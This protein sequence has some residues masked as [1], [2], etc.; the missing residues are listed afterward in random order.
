MSCSQTSKTLRPGMAYTFSCLMIQLSRIV[1]LDLSRNGISC[2]SSTISSVALCRS[3]M[4]RGAS[5]KHDGKR[6]QRAFD[7]CPVPN[8]LLAAEGCAFMMIET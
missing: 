8:T 5:S 3:T 7:R 2:S 6:T 4:E 1:P